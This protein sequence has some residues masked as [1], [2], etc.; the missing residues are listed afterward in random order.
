MKVYNEVEKIIK[1]NKS[2]L[3]GSHI[4]PDGDAIGSTLALGAALET[5]G[6]QVLIY[7][8]DAVPDNLKFLKG[9][10]K[11]VQSIPNNSFDVG[12]MV[13]CAS[14]DRAGEPFVNA[15]IAN[16]MIVI[17]HHR[18]DK[19]DVDVALLDES[20]AS[21]GEVVLRLI[22]HLKVPVTKDIAMQ[23]YC[24][25]AVDT[26]FFRYSNTTERILRV[27]ANLVAKGAHPWTV[28]MNL[29]E[30][31]RIERF[32][33]L[34][35]ALDTLEISA[36]GKYA[37]MEVTQKMISETKAPIQ[38]SE[39]F[40]GIPR[41]IKSVKVSALF[42]EIESG[43]VR[44]SLR[45]KNGIDVAAIA[46][47]FGGGGHPYAAGCTINGTVAEAKKIVSDIVSKS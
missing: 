35:C 17:D 16:M 43:K 10:E 9:C 39:E 42:R 19:I 1:S 21:A 8:R 28:A 44:V 32:R 26:G 15:K 12:I 22:E 34:A 27:A 3:I 30:S 47:K 4:N 24:T 23:V 2:F 41:S 25:L 11:I 29:E 37:T 40:A 6:K 46:S 45:S 18:Q 38:I 5:L 31:Y 7:N 14:K 13:D 20:A 33:L 36:D